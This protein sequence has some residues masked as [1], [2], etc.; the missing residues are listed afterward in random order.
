[1]STTEWI[2]SAV[3]IFSLGSSLYGN[4]QG[5]S[6]KNMS[7]WQNEVTQQFAILNTK[8]ETIRSMD[9]ILQKLQ[10][11]IS[12]ILS[13]YTSLL[14]QVSLV[15]TLMLGVAAGSFGA[16]LGNTDDQ[17]QWK[18]TMYCI[19]C[20][21]TICLSV[22]SVIEAFF[23]S[24]H[25][26]GEESRFI[27]GVSQH[28]KK[29][30]NLPKNLIQGKNLKTPSGNGINLTWRTFNTDAI[31]GITS[32]YSLVIITFFLSFLSFSFSLLSM[33]FV[34]LGLSESVFVFDQNMIYDKSDMFNQSNT[35]VGELENGYVG[36]A[37]WLTVIVIFTY[38]YIIASFFMKYIN[39]IHWGK[40]SC[41]TKCQKKGTTDVSLKIPMAKTAAEF[42]AVQKSIYILYA[43]F[44]ILVVDWYQRYSPNKKNDRDAYQ[45]RI[46]ELFGKEVETLST[47]MLELRVIEIGDNQEYIIAMRKEVANQKIQPEE[48]N[49]LKVINESSALLM[50]NLKF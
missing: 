1:M 24:I 11:R 8:A 27:A 2:G 4:R 5:N 46:I 20:I 15:S 17:P 10:S 36:N 39:D 7:K 35:T 37:I 47:K 14:N 42:D 29:A 16:L 41:C 9:E 3:G 44:N 32:S 18:V 12:T 28:V 43:E 26:Y 13:D 22:I 40:N 23:L 31:K 33:L 45:H 21:I 6:A 38:S 49:G 25:I 34:G 48:I 19:S 50:A 30:N